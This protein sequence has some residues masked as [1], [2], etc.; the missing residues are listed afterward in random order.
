MK[1]F[2]TTLAILATGINLPGTLLAQA[3]V[4]ADLAVYQKTSGVSGNIS[5]IGSDTLANLMTL[6]AEEFKRIYPN[7]NIQIQAAGSS[8]APPA[9]TEGT[10]NLGPMSRLMKDKE[11]ESF[12]K[13][14]GY[15][16]TPVAVAI[17]AL[18]VFVHKDNPI[19]GLTL[20]QTDAIF[21]STRNCGY[22][23]DIVKWGQL[24]LEGSWATR[25]IQLYGR[26]SVSGTYG[27][28][29]EHALCKGDFKNTVNE[30]PGS[31][32]VVQSVSSSLNG[33]GYSGIGYTTSS[34]RAVPLS[35]S[36]DKPFVDATPDNAIN[37]SYPLAR[38]LYIYV[39]KAPGKELDPITEQFLTMVLSRQGQEVVVKD[40]YI[41]LPAKVAVR[42]LAKIQ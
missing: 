11:V 31:A 16:P 22:P 2:F 10:A 17:D 13:R 9:L 7:V 20:E 5:S 39:N 19:A 24:A 37:G 26:N 41:P 28:F 36:A 29:K 18:A 40:G 30:Q 35:T 23:E 38:F 21:S 12:E 3:S 14:H 8:T 27:Y 32:S 25:G 42:E 34:V 6:W 1:S 4:D 33:I 15:K